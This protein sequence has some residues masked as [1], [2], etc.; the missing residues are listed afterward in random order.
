MCAKQTKVSIKMIPMILL[1]DQKHVFFSFCEFEDELAYITSYLENVISTIFTKKAI[2]IE[3][4]SI[5]VEPG[6]KSQPLRK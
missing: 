1:L 4:C 5:A 3:F 6:A 2:L